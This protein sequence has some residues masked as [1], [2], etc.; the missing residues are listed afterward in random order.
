VPRLWVKFQQGG[1]ARRCRRPSSQR[2]LRIPI[3]RG[4]V[5]K[6]ILRALGL[7]ALPLR[8]RRRRADAADLLR[9]YAA[10]PADLRGLRHDRELRRLAR[11]AAGVE[12]PARSASRT[13]ACE[14]RIDPASGEIQ[15]Q[16]PG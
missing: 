15:M 4:L 13:T 6:K 10:R 16:S 5:A 1:R 12:R 3:V 2:L 11:H 8:R 14:T 9:W 7:D